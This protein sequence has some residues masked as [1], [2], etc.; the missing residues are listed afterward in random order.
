MQHKS[1]IYQTNTHKKAET[2]NSIIKDFL[3]KNK[4]TTKTLLEIHTLTNKAAV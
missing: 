2:E 3:L 1:T 4:I